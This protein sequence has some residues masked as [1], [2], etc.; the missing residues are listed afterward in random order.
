MLHRPSYRR[1]WEKKLKWYRKNGVLPQEEGGGP[2][3]T[4]VT[5]E[6]DANGS[7]SSYDIEEMVDD[8]LG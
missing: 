2:K 7:I 6:D 3:G 1:N 8:L 5:T 4:L